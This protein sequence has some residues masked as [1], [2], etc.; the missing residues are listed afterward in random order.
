MM[1]Y[2]CSL[3]L[4]LLQLKLAESFS[5]YL[6]SISSGA[7]PRPEPDMQEKLAPEEWYGVTN[8]MANNWPGSKHEEF[9]GYLHKLQN[10]GNDQSEETKEATSGW[11]GKL[12]PMASWGGYKDPRWGGYLESLQEQGKG[13]ED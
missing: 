5:N 2:K 9:G 1:I 4:I 8:P 6:N 13:H 10:G 11:Y 12:N 3:L 7:T